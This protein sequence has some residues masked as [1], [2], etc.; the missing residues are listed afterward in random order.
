MVARREIV[1]R[2]NGKARITVPEPEPVGIIP[3]WLAHYSQL[4]AAASKVI[5]DYSVL[6]EKVSPEYAQLAIPKWSR[7]AVFSSTIT[8]DEKAS[9]LT[10]SCERFDRLCQPR[11][12]A[13]LTQFAHY[14]ARAAYDMDIGRE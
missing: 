6:S 8:R 10:Y 13:I 2:D 14:T 7:S 9:T 5:G 4:Q 11:A 3:S 1:R 12:T